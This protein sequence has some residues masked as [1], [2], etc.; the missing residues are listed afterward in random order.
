MLNAFLSLHLIR[1]QYH[2]HA[3]GA[4]I[5]QDHTRNGENNKTKISA[6]KKRIF[7]VFEYAIV[8]QMLAVPH[9]NGGTSGSSSKLTS[10]PDPSRKFS[11]GPV[12][13]PGANEC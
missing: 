4:E 5:I 6:I 8:A 11:S 2:N 1:Y 3:S 9:Q 12:F 10:L 13:E 7:Q